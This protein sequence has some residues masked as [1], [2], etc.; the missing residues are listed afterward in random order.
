MTVETLVRPDIEQ[1]K[2]AAPDSGLAAA[3][4]EA[5]IRAWKGEAV[6]QINVPASPVGDADLDGSLALGQLD[7][8]EIRAACQSYSYWDTSDCGPGSTYADDCLRSYMDCPSA[9]VTGCTAHG[10]CC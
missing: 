10:Y 5:I 8:G 1:T 3:Q 9:F 6:G 7:L 2:A 4:F